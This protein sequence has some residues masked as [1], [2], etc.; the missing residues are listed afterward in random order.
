MMMIFKS[1]PTVVLVALAH[2]VAYGTSAAAV[3]VAADNQ[4]VPGAED[5]TPRPNLRGINSILESDNTILLNRSRSSGS[6][7]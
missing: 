1:N 4:L 7:G 3:V 2:F 6:S 5:S